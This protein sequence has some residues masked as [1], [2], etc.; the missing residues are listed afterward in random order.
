MKGTYRVEGLDYSKLHLAIGKF[1]VTYEQFTTELKF[2]YNCLFQRYG[3]KNWALG[4]MLL[5]TKGINVN[6]L[7]LCFCNAVAMEKAVPDEI[8]ERARALYKQFQRVVELR[9]SIAH[10]EWITQTNQVI[11]TDDLEKTIDVDNQSIGIKRKLQKGGMKVE[12]LPAAVEIEEK[13]ALLI[14]LINELNSINKELVL[15]MHKSGKLDFQMGANNPKG[16]N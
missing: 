9:N 14:S 12:E 16:A 7:M 6:E 13:S 10:G 2:I 5:H 4:E 3:L 15:A 8:K 11:I 1:V